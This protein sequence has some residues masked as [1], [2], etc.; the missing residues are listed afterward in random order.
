MF[1]DAY[2][3]ANDSI[4]APEALKE[5]IRAAWKE[6]EPDIS[7]SFEP[8]KKRVWPR[9][10][11]YSGAAI[12]TA[13]LVLLV[14]RPFGRDRTAKDADVS[15][16]A[17]GFAAEESEEMVAEVTESKAAARADAPIYAS[18]NDGD[19]YF[20]PIDTVIEPTYADVWAYLKQADA[21]A[22]AEPE[23]IA[24]DS[25]ALPLQELA[26]SSDRTESETEASLLPEGRIRIAS[27]TL[28]NRLYLLSEADGRTYVN[29]FDAD[30][31]QP[32]GEGAAAG[33][34]V[35]HETRETQLIEPDV[36]VVTHLA[37][38]LTT[39]YVPDLS[40]ATEDDPA[41]YCPDVTDQSGT[42][43]LA[44]DEIT[45]LD[46]GDCFTVYTAFGYTEGVTVLFVFAELSAQ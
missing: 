32:L 27:E 23:D 6:S 37:L 46:E 5:T 24:A 1:R 14:V 10:L 45:P 11:G 19:D 4:H 35:A 21:G 41:S 3:K 13:A 33:R 39:E 29:V 31:L 12:A 30:T 20:D 42:R 34:Y 18:S 38:I 16:Q 9:V 17:T 25:E 28:E 40:K 8:T 7:A 22:L 44:A 2:R 43:T 26:Q 15:M 36:G